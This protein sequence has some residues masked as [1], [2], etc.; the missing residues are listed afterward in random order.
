MICFGSYRQDHSQENWGLPHLQ[1]I[2]DSNDLSTSSQSQTHFLRF[3][4]A[5][6]SWLTVEKKL[7]QNV[8]IHTCIPRELTVKSTA[9]FPLLLQLS[10]C[11]CKQRRQIVENNLSLGSPSLLQLWH[12]DC[13]SRNQLLFKGEKLK[14]KQN[15]SN[16]P[17]VL[18]EIVYYF[19]R[20]R[21]WAP[22]QEMLHVGWLYREVLR[23]RQDG[24]SIWDWGS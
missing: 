1:K 24:H 16:S 17:L 9:Q 18:D 11:P 13:I 5:L 3:S 20:H 21:H 19:S 2:C 6:D 14:T 23:G 8:F 4:L 22:H 10:Q 15:K 7:Y 12:D